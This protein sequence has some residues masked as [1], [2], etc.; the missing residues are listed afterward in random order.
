M[1]LSSNQY[2]LVWENARTTTAP[3]GMVLEGM[4]AKGSS[5][6]GWRALGTETAYRIQRRK[7][8]ETAFLT[9]ATT[10]QTYYTDT[11]LL[12]YGEAYE[13]Q[14]LALT[15]NVRSNTVRLTREQDLYVDS[16]L[17]TPTHFH[18]F[19]V[20]ASRIHLTWR[21][22]NE[23]DYL[24]YQIQYRTAAEGEFTDLSTLTPVVSPYGIYTENDPAYLRQTESVR[25]FEHQIG[26]LELPADTYSVEYRIRSVVGQILVSEWSDVLSVRIQGQYVDCTASQLKAVYES[27][28]EHGT[29]VRVTQGVALLP[30]IYLIPGIS[31]E[32]QQGVELQFTA[33]QGSQNQW[34]LA[35]F[36]TT[37]YQMTEMDMEFRQVRVN[38]MDYQGRAAWSVRQARYVVWT[39]C[40]VQDTFWQGI[41]LGIQTEDCVIDQCYLENAGYGPP[42]AGDN[43]NREGDGFIGTICIRGNSINIQ[44]LFCTFQC[45]KRSY[46]VKQMIDFTVYVNGRY[47]N[48]QTDTLGIGNV[49][50]MG[51]RFWQEKS[52]QF[53]WEI[54]ATD[55]MRVVLA[56]NRFRNQ[57]SLEHR[58]RASNRG[59]RFSV[60]VHHNDITVIYKAAIEASNHDLDIRFNFIDMSQNLKVEEVIGDYNQ[61]G[62]AYYTTDQ[63]TVAYNLIYCGTR[64]ANL[65]TSRN[66]R[67][68]V[69]IYGN[70]FVSTFMPYDDPVQGPQEGVYA[71]YNIRS[72][73]N[74]P[75]NIHSDIY[76]EN[77]VFVINARIPK[78]IL[79]LSTDAYHGGFHNYGDGQAIVTGTCSIKGN[80]LTAMLDTKGVPASAGLEN[81]LFGE[82]AQFTA[83]GDVKNRYRPLPTGNLY[84]MG[85]KVGRKYNGLAPNRGCYA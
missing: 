54:W 36:E 45:E 72:F 56:A 23:A 79:R 85:S 81:N 32:C 2:K 58:N 37:N 6:L 67:S 71:I 69:R 28:F 70:T 82:I 44:I 5:Y 3:I 8:G 68:R 12:E 20:A 59:H 11:G 40:A 63:L 52:P 78:Y 51:N 80:L 74:G 16:E 83:T 50:E 64:V 47:Y 46:G 49:F 10:A 66:Q 15:Q 21:K 53:S 62:A 39:Q 41:G 1:A 26:E 14:V 43:W 73:D 4:A 13:Y 35:L 9:L 57:L 76:I 24:S 34:N 19:C 7:K 60:R 31:I 18:G 65:I 55:S 42:E 48:L 84:E 77:N 61:D 17:A 22:G 27:Q 25:Y 38:G 29:C 30:S 33:N 75:V